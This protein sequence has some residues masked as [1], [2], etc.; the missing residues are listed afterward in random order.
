MML[1]DLS[2]AV[3]SFD[4]ENPLLAFVTGVLV[5]WASGFTAHVAKDWWTH[6]RKLHRSSKTLQALMTGARR[7][8]R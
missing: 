2:D 5:H 6:R 8:K 7:R 1:W 4:P 3:D